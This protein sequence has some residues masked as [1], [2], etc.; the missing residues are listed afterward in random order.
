M[1]TQTLVEGI[2]LQS[3]VDDVKAED[4]FFGADGIESKCINIE[5]EV[6]GIKRIQ[7]FYAIPIGKGSL[8]IEIGSYAGAPE[9][10]DWKFEEMLGKFTLTAE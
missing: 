10:V 2:V 8:L 4:T 1:D 3:G 7:V 6:D 5:K 9:S